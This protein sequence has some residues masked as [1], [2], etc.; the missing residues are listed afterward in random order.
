MKIELI[1]KRLVPFTLFILTAFII[2][3]AKVNAEGGSPPVAV[4][5]DLYEGYECL[6]I[7]FD[8]SASFDPDGDILSYRWNFEGEWTE[9]S[10]NPYKHYTWNDDWSGE[11]ILEVTDGLYSSND[12]ASVII[13]NVAPTIFFSNPPYYAVELGSDL[14]LTCE[15]F[16]P[17]PRSTCSDT[18]EIIFDW[19]D[20]SSTTVYALDG[21]RIVAS[22]HIYSSLG[23]YLVTLTVTDDDGG[24]ASDVCYVV[25][26]GVY[27]GPDLLLNEGDT[28]TGTG[29]YLIMFTEFETGIVDYGDGG[30]SQPLN[31]GEENTFELNHLYEDDGVFTVTIL[32]LDYD[33]VVVGS[34][35]VI[36][37]VNN[38]APSII[39]FDGLPTD[40]IPVGEQ[41]GF[42]S[43][44]TDPGVL[45]THI[46]T[47]DWGDSITTS[48]SID[49]YIVTDSHSYA[50]PGVYTILLTV[51]DDDEGSDTEIFQYIVVYDPNAGFVTG[52]GWI[53]SPAGAYIIDPTLTGKASFGFVSKY[54]KGQTTPSGNTEFQFKAGNINLHSSS[55]DWLVIAGSKAMYKGT[56]TING[57]G[58]YGFMLS[59]IDGQL[60]GDDIDRFRIKIWDKDTGELI[61]DN[62]LGGDDNNDP[63]TVLGGGQI[64]I[65]KK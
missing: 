6:E 16:D 3:P 20:E 14:Y 5:G 9:W 33:N 11:I 2:L 55:Y 25:V 38:I 13:N 34:D 19:G 29:Y 51:T 64:V 24:V 30:G 40:P 45:D 22:N 21:E 43:M 36:V 27:A 31:F 32:L 4:A 23:G 41:I 17:T 18:Y 15:F 35:T 56:G 8:G 63:A 50:E 49:N 65:H 44:F 60:K 10:N 28:F 46:A 12:T 58:N 48:G 7:L 26:W 42:T 47:A 37:T 1:L 61:Y 59:A 54:K 53:N 52:G 39:S 57:E 62:N